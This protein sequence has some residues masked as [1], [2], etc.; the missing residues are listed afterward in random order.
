MILSFK[1]TTLALPLL[2]LSLI[3]GLGSRTVKTESIEAVVGEKN[4]NHGAP[5]IDLDRDR[6]KL[7]QGAWEATGAEVSDEYDD[8]Y[9]FVISGD[10]WNDRFYAETETGPAKISFAGDTLICTHS[11]LGVKKHLIIKL[12]KDEFIFQTINEY[13]NGYTYPQTVCKRQKE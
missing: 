2:T 8:G 12:T 5:R 3:F 4:Y 6:L 11:D 10:E 13:D 1:N 7:L 9:Y